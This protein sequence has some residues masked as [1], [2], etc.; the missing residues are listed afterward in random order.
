MNFDANGDGLGAMLSQSTDDV[1]HVISFASRSLMKAERMYCATRRE[2]QA[3]IW[4]IDQ[5]RP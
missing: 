4:S 5:F 2:M 1:K 3:L